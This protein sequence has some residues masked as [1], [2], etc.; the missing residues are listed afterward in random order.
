MIKTIAL[1]DGNNF[2]A[3]CE[4]MID[5][6]LTKHPLV[7]LSNNDGC[8]ISRSSEARALKI[9]MGIPYFQI[10]HKLKQLDVKVR[11]S[12]YELYGDMSLRLMTLLKAYCEALET[13]SIDEAFLQLTRP[14]DGTLYSWARQLRAIVYRNLGIT[15]A[16]GLGRNKVQAKL[17]NYLA[18][19][20]EKN[21][22]IFD[23]EATKDKDKW[24]ES[25]KIENVWGIGG[26]LAHWSKTH[27]IHNA[28][29]LRDM[30]RNQLRIKYGIIGI[31]LQNELR[32]E[33][34]I[35]LN[36]TSPPKKETCVSKSFSR[37]ITNEREL[38]EAIASH[39]IRACEKLRKQKQQAGKISIFARTS[40]YTSTFY[41][42]SSTK[43]L[44]VPSN[45]TNVLLKE[46]L[47]L[48][49][50]IYRPHVALRKAGVIM[51]NLQSVDYLQ[52]SLFESID[53]ETQ[54]KQEHL[55]QVID[56]INKQYG[57]NVITWC[58]SGLSKKWDMRREKL[59]IASTTSCE[60]IPIV[61]V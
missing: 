3:S 28:K 16:I 61:K 12:N 18:K 21:A 17:A 56:G 4:Q 6:S 26:K 60:K 37:A 42:Q 45:N 24:L 29:Q 44:E 9:P 23:L 20:I 10:S 34:C 30:P 48:I 11:S 54:R 39:V 58:A 53:I 15:I 49:K 47:S 5:P 35:E 55:M 32:G 31:R 52:H 41:S 33:R 46:A 7:I 8:I 27:G 57:S 43:K 36:L 59:S 22:G 2:Y 40:C 13:Y 25:V 50:K 14:R 1:V 51:Q 38:G 19:A